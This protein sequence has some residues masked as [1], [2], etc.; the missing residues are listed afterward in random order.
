MRKIDEMDI[1]EIVLLTDEQIDIMVRARCMEEGVPLE[2]RPP[3]SSFFEIPKTVTGFNVKGTEIW[4]ENRSAASELAE[5]L[6]K[7][8][9]ELRQKKYEWQTGYD[10][11]WLE[12]Y[13]PEVVIEERLFYDKQQ[14]QD[15]EALMVKRKTLKEQYESD[16][17]LYEKSR[18]KIR[19]ISDNIYSVYYEARKTNERVQRAKDT[20]QEYIALSNG[21]KEQAKIFFDKAYKESLDEKVY[22][23]LFPVE[24]EVI[25]MTTH[26]RSEI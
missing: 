22:S 19:R 8:R 2:P 24:I 14:I 17:K 11:E 5:L 12:N 21:D 1:N 4:F 23:E 20:F 15:K 9:A 25:Q 6:N 13:S 26:H 10:V 7:H 3:E 16:L 18:D